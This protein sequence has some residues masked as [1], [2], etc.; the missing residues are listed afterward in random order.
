[1]TSLFR[2]S[3]AC[4]EVDRVLA[5]ESL[6]PHAKSETLEHARTCPECG[7]AL[8][9]LASVDQTLA[10]S[11]PLPPSPGE[12]ARIWAGM[13]ER[14]RPASAAPW[15]AMAGVSVA[16]AIAV[17]A[18]QLGGPRPV[19]VQAPTI[20]AGV[21]EPLETPASAAPAVIASREHTTPMPLAR[22]V[23]AP[24][25]TRAQLGKADV[26]LDPGAV[27]YLEPKSPTEMDLR[28]FT[29]KASLEVAKLSASD[30]FEVT[31]PLAR[32]RVIGTK[33]SVDANEDRTRVEVQ[34][35]TV[36]VWE[37]GVEEPKVVNAGGSL[38]VR[39]PRAQLSQARAL[40]D[41]DCSGAAAIAGALVESGPSPE[42]E[43]EALLVLADAE[44]RRGDPTKA[45]GLYL[46]VVEHPNGAPY[47][48]E[49]SFKTAELR[50]QTGDVQGALQALSEAEARDGE[51]ALG[52]ERARLE[53]ELHRAIGHRAE[54]ARALDR[55]A[56][57]AR[58]AGDEATARAFEL[59][60]A[61]IR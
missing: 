4:R 5:L 8:S 30:A 50:R 1:M 41:S 38:D 17:A 9:T 55:G 37:N 33:F 47:R 7:S 45:A 25:T 21:L 46:R 16:F 42:I 12:R 10:R 27:V 52:P 39:A 14:P 58:K 31:T 15:W 48:E 2:S 22:W 59:E 6:A 43:V 23:R 49:A 29:G 26:R 36:W 32:V 53:A 24:R 13:Q 35:G 28:L 54:A 57:R 20:V 51:G 60:R 11:V 34:E 61:K 3:A 44:R 19:D 18:I 56:L 40:L